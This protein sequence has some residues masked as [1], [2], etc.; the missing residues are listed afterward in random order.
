MSGEPTEVF[1]SNLRA[2]YDQGEPAVVGAMQQ[3][4]G[5]AQEARDVLIHR[6]DESAGPPDQPEFRSPSIDLPFAA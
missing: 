3:F 5:L 4:A 2:R 1:H 6:A